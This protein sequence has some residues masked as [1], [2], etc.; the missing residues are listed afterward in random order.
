MFVAV[1]VQ[2]S[3]SPQLQPQLGIAFGIELD[4]AEAVGCSVGDERY[5][6]LLGHIVV[7]DNKVFV[8]DRFDPNSVRFI[9]LFSNQTR[10]TIPQQLM[11]ALSVA[12]RI[13]PQIGQT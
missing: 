5:E 10:S 3:L 11:S 6:V 1:H 8:L 2:I 4:H 12:W 13:L 7:D 9:W